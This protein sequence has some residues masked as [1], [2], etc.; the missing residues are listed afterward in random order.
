MNTT[1]KCLNKKHEDIS[2]H[3]EGIDKKHVAHVFGLFCPSLAI[4]G[5]TRMHTKN[6]CFV[7]VKDDV[8]YARCSDCACSDVDQSGSLV[9]IV[10]GTG[11]W[12]YPWVKLDN[13]AY[14]RMIGI[15]EGTQQTHRRK[16]ART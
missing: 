4:Q 15:H 6:G 1:M 3:I 8:V 14:S 2:K 11:G 10:E 12:Q 5:V 7:A 9:E 16:K 13:E